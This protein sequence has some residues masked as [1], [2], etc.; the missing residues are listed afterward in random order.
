[1]PEVHLTP[2]GPPETVLDSEPAEAIA[3]LAAALELPADQ[4]RA[5]VAEAVA[6]WPKFLDGWARLGDLGRD[7]IERY[8]AY[9]VGYH[10]GLDRLRA[11]G[12]RGSGYVR[13]EHPVNRGFLRALAGLHATAALIG[14]TEE[15][16]RCALFLRQLDP[17]W[18]P[19]DLD[20]A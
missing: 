14:E 12:W 4:R 5:A 19:S 8:A 3:A 17:A 1:M 10:R 13:W 9:R 15:A 6:R 7:V 2:S 16:E 11:N 20:A 18:P